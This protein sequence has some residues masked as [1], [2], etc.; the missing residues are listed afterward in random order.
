MKYDSDIHHRRSI[1]LRGYDYSRAGVYFVTLGTH[2]RECLFG[3]IVDGGMVLND[4]GR[5]VSEEW[6][7]TPILRPDLELDEF[8]VMPNHFHGIIIIT[9][10][11]TAHRADTIPKGTA[12]RAPTERFGKP[13]PGSVPTIIRSFKSAVT[14]RVNEMRGT[15]GLKLWQRNYYEHII[16]NETEL[17]HIREYIINNPLKWDLD[18][19]NPARA[20]RVAPLPKN[21][22]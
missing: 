5:I 16:R 9:G 6:S 3:Q 2:N 13:V 21:E 4:A 11:D 8:V 17:N 14:R 12:H 15:S 22:P 1:R 20:R 18:R 10:R 19:E 7:N